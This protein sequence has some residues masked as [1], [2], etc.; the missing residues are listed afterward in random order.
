MRGPGQAPWKLAPKLQYNNTDYPLLDRHTF[1]SITKKSMEIVHSS[2]PQRIVSFLKLHILLIFAIFHSEIFWL[3]VESAA[4]Q[5][6]H[7]VK[8]IKINPLHCCFWFLFTIYLYLSFFLK[9]LLDE[10]LNLNE[11][12]KQPCNITYRLFMLWTV[13]ISFFEILSS[14]KMAECILTV[15]ITWTAY[16]QLQ[17]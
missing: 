8:E 6:P 15:N 4:A 5:L 11:R 10:K 17:S 12:Q 2:K 1:Q 7:S 3:D 16:I 14:D 13:V 9:I